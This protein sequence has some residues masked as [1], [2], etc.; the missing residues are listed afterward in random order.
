MSL[1]T[2]SIRYPVTVAV[3]VLLAFLGG[4]LALTAVPIQLTPDVDR[5]VINVTTSWVGASP[6]EIEKEIIEEQED[7]LKSVEGVVK[8]DSESY[9][10]FGQISMEFAVGTDI[11]GA[12]V[13]VTNKLNEVPSYPDNADRPVVSS[14]GR[15]DRAIAW[16][17]IKGDSGVYVPH[18]LT[19]VEDVVKPRL[20]RVEGVSAVNVFG[21]LEREVHVTF[22]PELLA[23]TGITV[24]DMSNALRSEN[25]DISAGDF[26]EGKRRY[27]VRTVSRFLSTEDIEQTIV[28][29]RNGVSI[30]VGDVADVEL[31]YQKPYAQV[32]HKGRP[33]L[34]FNVQRRIGANVLEVTDALMLQVGVLNEEILGPRGMTLENVYRETV[35]I[36]SAVDRVFQNIFIGGFLAIA[37]LFMFLRS[38][39][40]ILVIGLSI[41]ISIITTFLTMFLFG[42]T[43][44][45]ISLAGMAFAVGM[46]V[47]NAIVVLENIYRHLQ[48]GKSRWQAANEGTREVWGAVLASTMTTVAVFLPIVFIQERAGQLFRDIAIAIS[49]AI[50]VSLIVSVTVIP[51]AS[52]KILK[53]S[54]SMKDG[55]GKTR[56]ALFAERIATVVDYINAT[57]A[58][59]LITIVGIVAISVG[60]TL[61]LLPA[62][63]YLPNG[64]QNFIFGFMLPPPGYNLDEMVKLGQS[65]EARLGYLWETPE[66]EAKDIPGGGV[67]NFFF[68][69]WGQQAFMGLRARDPSRCR[70]LLPVA[71]G[72]LF[73]IPGTLGFANQASL[74]ARGFAGTRSVKIDV[75]G[76]DLNKV[77]V[78]ARRVFGQVSQLIPGA[79]SRPIPGLDLGNPEV[80][81]YPD[82]ARAADVGF[83]ATDIGLTV[84]S[85]VDGM[86]VSEYF[87]EGRE[88]DLVLRGRDDWTNHTQNIEQLPIATPSGQIITLGDIADVRQQ[89]GPVQINHVER[90]RAV[91]IETVLPDDI[92][93][94]EAI[95][96][97][98]EGIVKPLRDDGQIGGLYDVHQTGSADDLSKLRAALRTNFVVVILLTYLLLASLFQSFL[99]PLVIMFTVPLATFGGVLGLRIVQFFDSAQQLDVLTML[100]FVILVGT[101][102]NNSILIVYQALNLMRDEGMDP[103]ESVK[104]SVRVRVRPIFMSTMTSTLGM[105]PLV[106][107]PGAGSELYRGLGSVVVGGLALSTVFTLLLTPLVFSYAIEANARLRRILGREP[108]PAAG[109]PAMNGKF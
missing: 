76:P 29:V 64:N 3:G 96:R 42:R 80:R 82:R 13:R 77:L 84:N 105:L 59:R 36:H 27:V 58:R 55:V 37:I 39:S 68:V 23:S 85:L 60:F 49:S 54:S 44:N 8:M 35:Y 18:M 104:E 31:S 70:E 11:T 12:T 45:V 19:F 74:F 9:D 51:A 16:F 41:P 108:L 46:V 78:L 30:R 86:E 14:S 48:M 89:Q 26:G 6:E 83:S 65:I 69:A 90:Q 63:E 38:L 95:G 40:S 109:K 22:A 25:R 62:S 2:S 103:R 88:I 79:Q 53:I 94:E 99:Y 32:R 17:V 24:S 21:G 81:V 106:V 5:P 52:A 92:A 61:L 71:N 57:N 98:E 73:T 20:E 87:H 15:F 107:M 1:V 47:D 4:F 101:V 67:D 50:V 91:S 34:A 28:A 93:L 43:I 72:T 100:G 66:Q 75:T 56:L 10:G 33:A 97:I 102:I 7:Y